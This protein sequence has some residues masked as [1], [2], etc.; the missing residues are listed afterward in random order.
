MVGV[1]SGP[2]RRR[3]ELVIAESGGG[4]VGAERLFRDDHTVAVGREPLIGDLTARMAV[5]G[6]W[7]WW[8]S[9]GR[10]SRR[11]CAV[12]DRLRADPELTVVSVLVGAS[13]TGV[14]G[15]DVVVRLVEQLQ[16]LIGRELSAPTDGDE[17]GFIQWWRDVLTEA[18]T[19]IEGRLVIVVDALDVWLMIGPGPMCGR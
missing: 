5:G 6:R 4:W 16:P 11:F 10:G 2:V 3:A 7:C 12:E 13:S 14:S 15:R 1:L 17:D 18:Q 19:A 8:V 9:R